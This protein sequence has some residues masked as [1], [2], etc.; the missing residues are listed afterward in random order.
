MTSTLDIRIANAKRRVEAERLAR[1]PKLSAGEFDRDDHQTDG[2]RKPANKALSTTSAG[3]GKNRVASHT[4]TWTP[5]LVLKAG[6][7]LAGAFFG[8]LQL[9]AD[10]ALHTAVR[11][12]DGTWEINPDESGSPAA[13]PQA[14]K[15][16]QER[17]H[18]QDAPATEDARQGQ[19]AAAPG[20][21]GA[22]QQAVL[23]AVPAWA[24]PWTTRA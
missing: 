21:E 8:G 4:V 5:P 19:D 20:E 18:G 1:Q 23:S 10:C 17:H 3:N 9:D 15:H 6:D 14:G 11:Y 2:T 13:A 7:T 16:Q 22:A 12:D 24:T